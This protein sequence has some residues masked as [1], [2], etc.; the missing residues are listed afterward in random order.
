L[1]AAEH[2]YFLPFVLGALYKKKFILGASMRLTSGWQQS[3]KLFLAIAFYVM[4]HARIELQVGCNE[5]FSL[6]S[7]F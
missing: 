7:W 1:V 6:A 5:I 3:Y 2:K 4:I